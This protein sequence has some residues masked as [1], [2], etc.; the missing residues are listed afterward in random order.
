MKVDCSTIIKIGEKMS[1]EF[2]VEEKDTADYLGNKGVTVL[3]TPAMIYYMER[4][5][6]SVVFERAPE[7]YRPVGT[8]ID[9]RHINPTPVGGR[10]TVNAAVKAVD[11]NKVTYDVEAFYGDVK[12][13]YGEYEI[14]VIDLNRF[15]S[16]L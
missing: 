13:G 5:A 3:S 1:E 16:K 4:T 8:R 12:I 2:I 15:K 10:I 9:V 6:S 14:H 11:G 7:N